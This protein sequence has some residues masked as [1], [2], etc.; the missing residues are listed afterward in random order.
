MRKLNIKEIAI[1]LTAY[2]LMCIG[3]FAFSRWPIPGIVFIGL[4]IGLIFFYLKK[5]RTKE[6]TPQMQKAVKRLFI[7]IFVAALVVAFNQMG[8]IHLGP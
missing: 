7:V 3:V 5:I 2:T 4:G 8:F 1:T 6:Q